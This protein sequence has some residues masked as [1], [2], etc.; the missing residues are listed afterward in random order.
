MDPKGFL[1]D[2][3]EFAVELLPYVGTLINK[4]Q[5]E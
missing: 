4:F 5:N 1:K 2:G 3:D